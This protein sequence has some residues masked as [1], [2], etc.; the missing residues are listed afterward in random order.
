MP[1]ASSNRFRELATERVHTQQEI[2]LAVIFGKW[3]AVLSNILGLVTL[4]FILYA[5]LYLL[6]RRMNTRRALNIRLISQIFLCLI[7]IVI[8][9]KGVLW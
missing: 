6:T 9:L 5:I 2:E 4:S 8:F 1:L 7:L 3:F